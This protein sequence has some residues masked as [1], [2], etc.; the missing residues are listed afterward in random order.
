MAESTRELELKEK[1]REEKRKNKEEKKVH[2]VRKDAAHSAKKWK[3]KDWFVIFS[4]KMF[5]ERAVG[6]T[7]ATN[8]KTLAGRNIEVSMSD[9]TGQYGKDFYRVMLAVERIDGN[10]LH[11]RFNGYTAACHEGDKE[12]DA[13]DREHNVHRYQGQMETPD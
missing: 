13:E 7:P 3:G 1:E 4:P 5:G 9:L 10:T 6:E 2:Q 12:E 8:P 11:T